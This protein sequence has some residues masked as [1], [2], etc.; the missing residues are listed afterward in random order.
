M[1]SILN[2][3]LQQPSWKDIPHG[4]SLQ[5]KWL[6]AHKALGMSAEQIYGDPDLNSIL[7]HKNRADVPQI[8]HAIRNIDRLLGGQPRHRGRPKVAK[9]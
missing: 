8:M 5:T 3:I 9:C 6:Y 4:I 1:D 7:E 2:S